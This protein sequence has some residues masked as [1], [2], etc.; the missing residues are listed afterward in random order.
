M[1]SGCLDIPDRR[2]PSTSIPT[3]RRTLIPVLAIFSMPFRCLWTTMTSQAVTVTVQPMLLDLR[4]WV[5]ELRGFEPLT[6][7]LRTRCATGLRHSPSTAPHDNTPSP[8]RSRRYSVLDKGLTA[9]QMTGEPGVAQSPTARR[10]SS[11]ASAPGAVAS[12]GRVVCSPSTWPD[13]QASGSPRSM[14]RTVR[15]ALALET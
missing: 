6:P 4:C 7:S 2:P 1:L 11:S 9:G 10:L 5:V 3:P 15:F 14:V 8:C 13:V 12:D